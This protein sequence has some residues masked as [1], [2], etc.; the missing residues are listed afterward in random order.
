MFHPFAPR[1]AG[2]LRNVLDAPE[3]PL[4]HSAG[5]EKANLSLMNK[6]MLEVDDDSAVRESVKKAF[7]EAGYEAVLAAGG[8]E[9]VARL[10]AHEIDVV[11]LDI[12]LSNQSGWQTWQ[13]LAREYSE[14]PII[15]ITSPTGQI[16]S[17]LAAGA[18]GLMERPLAPHQPPHRIQLLLARSKESDPYRSNGISYHAAA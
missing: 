7:G 15:V 2:L 5:T 16:K 11:L 17:S 18:S 9:E 14:A 4:L 13:H 8:L 1:S 6:T 10:L 12:G 3:K